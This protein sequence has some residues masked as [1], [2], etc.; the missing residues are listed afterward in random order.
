VQSAGVVAA[1]VGVTLIASGGG[2]SG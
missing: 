2:V 1:L